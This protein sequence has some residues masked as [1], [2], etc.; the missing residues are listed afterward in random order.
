[1]G[2]TEA[3]SMTCADGRGERA[4]ERKKERDAKLGRQA[5]RQ[6]R[7]RRHS[8]AERE[9]GGGGWVEKRERSRCEK[10]PHSEARA[11]QT[12][13]TGILFPCILAE[14]KIVLFPTLEF[15]PHHH[16][17][18]SPLWCLSPLQPWGKV[19]MR[20]KETESGS[21]HLLGWHITI[22]P[23]IFFK[24]KKTHGNRKI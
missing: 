8:R 3:L 7:G 10:S 17:P 21:D 13:L 1:M 22:C 5:G 20:D 18:P 19:S 14:G 2:G 15:S 9:D 12:N 4:K 6:D 24:K 11:G 23:D 16:H